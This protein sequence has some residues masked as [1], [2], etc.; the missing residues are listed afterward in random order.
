MYARQIILNKHFIG[1]RFF[2]DTFFRTP[3]KDFFIQ[4]CLRKDLSTSNPLLTERTLLKDENRDNLVH[5]GIKT[6]KI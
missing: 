4:F 5:T 1:K 6:G 2:A 3:E